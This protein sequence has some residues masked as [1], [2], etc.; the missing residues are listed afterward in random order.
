MSGQ[1]NELFTSLT[2][3]HK[4]STK[5]LQL[6]SAYILA[7]LLLLAIISIVGGGGI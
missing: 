3:L 7:N 4:R 1:T 5:Y 2:K 6:G